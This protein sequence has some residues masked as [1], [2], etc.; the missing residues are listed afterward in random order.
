[1][2]RNDE[3]NT[4]VVRVRDHDGRLAGEKGAVEDE[5]HAL[6]RLNRGR[7]RGIFEPADVVGEDAGR[8]HD[9]TGPNLAARARLEVHELGAR[10]RAVGPAEAR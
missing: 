2:P 9:D 7:R 6:R 8:V 1:M 10:D 3:E 5:V 4:P